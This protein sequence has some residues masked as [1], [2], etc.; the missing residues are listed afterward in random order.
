LSAPTAEPL[1][2]LHGVAVML[3]EDNGDFRDAMEAILQLCGARTNPVASLAEA[4]A[5]LHAAA[6]HV[7]VSDLVLPDGTGADFIEWLRELPPDQGGA[8]AV[9][10]VTAFPHSFPAAR[11]K[12]FA[13][14]LVKPVDLAA[15]CW[16]IASVLGRGN[17]AAPER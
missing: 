8:L 16:T 4:R 1:P 10:A 17:R 2:D 12:R 15:L 14:Y 7:V 3:L 5:Q 9:V 6:P 13:A 11:T